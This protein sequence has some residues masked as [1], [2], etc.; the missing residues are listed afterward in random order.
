MLAVGKGGKLT[1]LT[2]PVPK[3]K[4]SLPSRQASKSPLVMEVG[5]EVDADGDAEAEAEVEAELEAK[6]DGVVGKRAGAPDGS[7]CG[8]GFVGSG[9][10]CCR[11]LLP[12]RMVLKGRTRTMPDSPV[13]SVSWFLV[14]WMCDLVSIVIFY[15]LLCCV[16]LCHRPSCML[17]SIPLYSV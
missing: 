5:E 12:R 1:S 2:E 8:G 6:L 11:M 14:D 17:S 10:C 15:V 9:G 4:S 7:G 13:L 3:K 16:F